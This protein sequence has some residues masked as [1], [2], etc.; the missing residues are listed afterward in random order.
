MSDSHAARRTQVTSRRTAQAKPHPKR[1]SAWRWIITSLL[2]VALLSIGGFFG[3]QKVQDWRGADY[4]GSGQDE[5]IVTVKS[6]QTVAQMG[7][8]LAAQDVVASRNAFMRAARKEPRTNAIQ[9]GNYPM[10]TK[11]SAAAAIAVLVDSSNITHQ[12]FTIREG[13]RNRDVFK[14]ISSDTTIPVTELE[15]AA[16]RSGL[17]LPNYAQ[18]NSEGF[19]FPDTYTF[20]KDSSAADIIAKM[21]NRFDDVATE[22]QLEHYAQARG[23]SAHD[24]M[25]V[26]SIIEREASNAKYAPLV[27]EVIYNRLAKGMRLQ[28][29]ATVAYANN[30]EGRVT[31]TD[32]ERGLDSAYNTYMSDG[33]PPSP[34]SNPGKTAIQAA[35]NPAKG[36]LLYFVTVNLDSGETKFASD[37]EGHHK[38][39]EEFQSWCRASTHCE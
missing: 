16:K 39:V 18:H 7:D 38:N 9:A 8:S 30:I 33:L 37:D 6:G 24:V 15:S 27:A 35:L 28:S 23:R 14:Q 29:D 12:Q 19:L 11:M 5:V 26:A 31:T 32:E 17:A 36:D 3:Y 10:R 34:I 20:E 2:V 22:I 4:T 13:L 1:K 21:V 25:V